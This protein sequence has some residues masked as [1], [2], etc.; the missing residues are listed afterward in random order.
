[1]KITIEIDELALV[2]IACALRE[3][4]RAIRADIE[5][6]PDARPVFEACLKHTIAA[7]EALADAR[8]IAE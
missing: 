5:R 6:L 2:E 7:S 1:M 8:S 3:R 4:E